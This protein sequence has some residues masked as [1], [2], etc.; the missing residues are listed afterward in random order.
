MRLRLARC[1][2]DDGAPSHAH[3]DRQ[4]GFSASR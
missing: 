1:Q 2:G 3:Q 4:K